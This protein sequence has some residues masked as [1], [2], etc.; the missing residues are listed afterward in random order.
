MNDSI[1]IYV[2]VVKDYESDF[3]NLSAE[4]I[5]PNYGN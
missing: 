5:A 4:F 1:M 3:L 2:I